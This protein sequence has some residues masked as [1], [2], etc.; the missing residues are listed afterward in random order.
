M[1][2]PILLSLCRVCSK[3]IRIRLEHRRRIITTLILIIHQP[4]VRTS[5]FRQQDRRPMRYVP[6]VLVQAKL[7]H[8][9][10]LL[11]FISTTTTTPAVHLRCT[12]LTF[13][14]C[15]RHF[16][17]YHFLSSNHSG[18]RSFSSLF[19][20]SPL[21]SSSSP[22]LISV[23]LDSLSPSSLFPVNVLLIFKDNP[24]HSPLIL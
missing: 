11:L 1:V 2:T 22:E 20:S 3:H 6:M 17:S 4:L 24:I 9:L 21:S 8:F 15:D 12:R 18:A 13:Y 5:L 7:P 14:A 23:H 19:F 10:H 16:S